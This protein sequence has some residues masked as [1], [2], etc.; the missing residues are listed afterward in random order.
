MIQYYVVIL[1]QIGG[2]GGGGGDLETRRSTSGYVFQIQSNTISWCSRRQSSVAR[3]TTE[4]EYI[5]LSNACQESVWLRLLSDVE[6][7]HMI[8]QQFLRTIKEQ[9]NSL[10]I[11]DFTTELNI[12]MC[13]IS[14]GNKSNVM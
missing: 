2:G 12:L 5:A 14:L 1:M 4:A 13:L 7:K 6:S 3:S 9:Y 11:Q 8:R 10:R